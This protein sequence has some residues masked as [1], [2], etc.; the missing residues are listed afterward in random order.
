[1]I[2]A[3]GTKG[4]IGAGSLD[5]GLA[6]VRLGAEVEVGGMSSDGKKGGEALQ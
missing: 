1:L 4:S 6:V 3:L 2:S 5:A